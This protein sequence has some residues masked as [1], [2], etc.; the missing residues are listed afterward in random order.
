[1]FFSF[2]KVYLLF[3]GHCGMLATITIVSALT[4]RRSQAAGAEDISKPALPSSFHA[5]ACDSSWL[6]ENALA[7]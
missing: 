7:K 6:L 1:M 5:I 2:A 4:A 3:C